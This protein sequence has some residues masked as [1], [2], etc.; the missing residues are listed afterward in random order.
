MK[1]LNIRGEVL[2]STQ[3]KT[4]S[5]PGDITVARDRD[6]VYTD[7]RNN[8]VHLVRDEETRTVITLQGWEPFCTCCSEASDLLVTMV[9]SDGEQSK[10]VRYTD[11]IEKQ[12]IQFDEEGRPLYLHARYISE[13]RN[14]DICVEDCDASAVVVV[15]MSGKLR[16]RYT[17]HPS[18]IRHS[19]N[20]AG[21]TTDS[22]GNILVADYN[23]DLVH[24]LDQDGQFL[25]CIR[26]L[27]GP[28]GLCVDIKDNLYVAE[29]DTAKVKKIQYLDT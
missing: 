7:Y 14:L 28:L 3:T 11:F 26:D 17:G 10:V 2:T 8:T 12:T 15:N 22:Q 23:N 4:E 9:S 25:S 5:Y 1:L 21:L 13:N 24:I 19:F 16:F 18:T 6:L 29:C 20:P 27:P